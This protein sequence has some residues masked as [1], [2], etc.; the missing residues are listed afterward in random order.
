[1]LIIM[2]QFFDRLNEG[3]PFFTYPLVLILIIMLILLAQGFLKKRKV[4]KIISLVNSMSLFALVW[5]FLGHI[6]GIIVA[7][8]TIEV[9]GDI[10]SSVL[11]RGLSL[12]LLTLVFG[13]SIFLIG[14]L[15]TIVLIWMQKE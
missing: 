12:T 10:S 13:S 7:L 15:G 9:V 6:V 3:G 8:D 1:M 4:K 11:V 2:L 14:R 5:S